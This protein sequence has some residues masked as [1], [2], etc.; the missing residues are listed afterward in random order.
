MVGHLEFLYEDGELCCR[1]ERRVQVEHPITEA[2]TG[3]DLV[4]EQIRVAAGHAAIYT[5]TSRLRTLL[6][7]V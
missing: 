6:N 1:N 7:A 3:V 5:K 2:I 4:R